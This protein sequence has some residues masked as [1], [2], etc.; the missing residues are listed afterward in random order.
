MSNNPKKFFE[1]NITRIA[2]QKE[3][4]LHNMNC[5]FLALCQQIQNL[6]STQTEI[7]QRIQRIEQILSSRWP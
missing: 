3:P 5:G 1:D 4:I 6:Q 2:P 7:A